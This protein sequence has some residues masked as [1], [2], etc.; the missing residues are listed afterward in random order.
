ML[1]LHLCVNHSHVLLL[2]FPGSL[3][4]PGGLKPHLSQVQA[5]LRF[6]YSGLACGGTEKVAVSWMLSL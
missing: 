5:I 6:K 1:R 4:A 3:W 2:V